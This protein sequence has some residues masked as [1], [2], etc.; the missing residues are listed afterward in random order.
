MHTLSRQARATV[1]APACSSD[2]NYGLVNGTLNRN[3]VFGYG[4]APVYKSFSN[5]TTEECCKKCFQSEDGCVAWSYGGTVNNTEPYDGCVMAMY[6]GGC[7]THW[8][9]DTI[10][11]QNEKKYPVGMGACNVQVAYFQG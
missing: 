4:E 9:A 1:T 8:G 11:Y 7:P 6:D 5:V 10:V 2:N 3:F